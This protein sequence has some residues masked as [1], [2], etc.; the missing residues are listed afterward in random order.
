MG[1]IKVPSTLERKDPGSEK[2]ETNPTAFH[3]G[4]VLQRRRLLRR[5]ELRK[6]YAELRVKKAIRGRGKKATKKKKVAVVSPYIWQATVRN[7]GCPE[8]DA[9]KG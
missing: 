6:S 3:L 4:H 8:G 9:K 7:V 2:N 5:P 1:P